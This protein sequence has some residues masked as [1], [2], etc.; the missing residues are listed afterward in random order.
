MFFIAGAIFKISINSFI[1]L[2]IQTL[3][4]NIDDF[5][6]SCTLFIIYY[7]YYYFISLQNFI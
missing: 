2:E 3:L 4:D 5:N 6:L 1:E 7:H